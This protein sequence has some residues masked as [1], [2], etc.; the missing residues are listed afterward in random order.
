[1]RAYMRFCQPMCRARHSVMEGGSTRAVGGHRPRRGG[2]G[3]SFCPM[4]V[5]PCP[6]ERNTQS[7]DTVQRRA[8]CAVDAKVMCR[9]PEFEHMWGD[10]TL[11][12][13]LHP[14]CGCTADAPHRRTG[15]IWHGACVAL[16]WRLAMIVW[17]I[18]VHLVVFGVIHGL[19]WALF[20]HNLIGAETIA[21]EFF[22]VDTVK[23][24]SFIFLGALLVAASNE[25]A[26]AFKGFRNFGNAVVTFAIMLNG[27]LVRTLLFR[28]VSTYTPSGKRQRRHRRRAI[29]LVRDSAYLLATLLYQ[30]I[31][32]FAGASRLRPGWRRWGPLTKTHMLA[33]LYDREAA[34]GGSGG[35]DDRR[36]PGEEY[37]CAWRQHALAGG[38]SVTVHAEDLAL[39]PLLTAEL[40][41]YE[42]A[43]T[44]N[45][46]LAMLAYRVGTL[47]NMG[48]LDT[49]AHAQLFGQINGMGGVLDDLA[50]EFDQPHPPPLYASYA[51]VG[52]YAM[53][54]LLMWSLWPRAAAEAG[55][56]WYVGACVFAIANVLGGFLLVA[57]N[58]SAVAGNIFDPIGS[59]PFI[60]FDTRASA[61]GAA[62]EIHTHL[63]VLLSQL[64]SLCVTPEITAQIVAANASANVCPADADTLTE[65]DKHD[66]IV[67][68]C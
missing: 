28:E 1:M 14:E 62:S 33:P 65:T 4:E 47:A 56:A 46:T 36:P 11:E 50:V 41:Q 51:R 58:L 9:F 38:T 34:C 15:G 66:T 12:A 43:D 59:S 21:R 37:H 40:A 26:V 3:G 64:Q 27:S 53:V 10:R 6:A 39:T 5:V 61:D 13:H 18:R 8:R 35:D 30:V 29:D 24:L 16:L 48:V 7:C 57:A 20:A 67:Q 44:I 49:A 23:W 60:Y 2:G 25:T 63:R 52:I 45:G 22:V 68:M 54:A 17:A 55:S 19:W 31:E 32:T 42:H